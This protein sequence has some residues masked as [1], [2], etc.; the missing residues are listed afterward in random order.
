MTEITT[1]DF[2]SRMNIQSFTLVPNISNNSVLNINIESPLFTSARTYDT[3]TNGYSQSLAS[4][5]VGPN[6]TVSYRDPVNNRN[7]SMYQINKNILNN[8]DIP[9]VITQNDGKSIYKVQNPERFFIK[10]TLWFYAQT[11]DER[12]FY[13]PS[14]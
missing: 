2:N 7:C 6:Y 12:Y 14:L 3:S 9:F 11:D 10:F 1:Q 8:F 13:I 4:F 5:P